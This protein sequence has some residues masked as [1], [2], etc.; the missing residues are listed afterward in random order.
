MFKVLV[1][2]LLLAAIG[3]L[4]YLEMKKQNSGSNFHENFENTVSVEEEEDE[5]SSETKEHFATLTD[6]EQRQLK[7]N[8]V[9]VP[10]DNIC[11]ERDQLKAEDLLPRESMDD[12]WA[13]S[14]PHAS[15]NLIKKDFLTSEMRIGVETKSNTIGNRDIRSMPPITRVEVGPWNQ[16][17]LDAEGPDKRVPFEIGSV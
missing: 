4:F 16:G 11:R 2:V 3:F 8:D 12:V 10:N 5:D 1:V 15:K 14:N 7:E 9:R 6:E 13:R 17:T